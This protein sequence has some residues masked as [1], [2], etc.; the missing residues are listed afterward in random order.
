MVRFWGQNVQTTNYGASSP[1]SGYLANFKVSWT[2]EKMTAGAKGCRTHTRTHF[3]KNATDIT[4]ISSVYDE[5]A[6]GKKWQRILKESTVS[7][8]NKWYM[9]F[10]EPYSTPNI[11]LTRRAEQ[12]QR[13]WFV[14]RQPDINNAVEDAGKSLR[15]DNMQEAQYQAVK[16]WRRGD[17]N[18]WKRRR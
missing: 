13:A 7:L 15:K 4:I 18:S 11:R 16:S 3:L 14:F 10:M 17:I 6:D 2:N 9:R 1:K 5:F 12:H 8:P